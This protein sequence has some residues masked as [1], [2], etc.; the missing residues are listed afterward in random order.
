M[1]VEFPIGKIR[2]RAF[3]IPTDKPEADGTIAWDST[4]LIVVE[5]TAGN[6]VGLVYTYADASI[7]ALIELLLAKNIAGLDAMIRR[8]P[9]MPWSAPCAIL[10]AR[11][12]QPPPSPQSTPHY[13][14]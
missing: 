14:I 4:T 9:G 8:P 13:M 5:V 1:K 12:S 7:T 6:I 11:V 3:I 10:V 2:A